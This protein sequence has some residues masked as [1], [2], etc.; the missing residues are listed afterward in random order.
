MY[1]A[2]TIV[3]PVGKPKL[4]PAECDLLYP[5]GRSGCSCH[6]MAVIWKLEEM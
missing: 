1:K 2:R 6:V 3:N 4:T 5:A